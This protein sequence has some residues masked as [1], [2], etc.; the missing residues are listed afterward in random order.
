[1]TIF[2]FT[3]HCVLPENVHTPPMEG[4]WKF[5]GDG[6]LKA[7]LLEELS[8]KLNWNFLDEEGGGGGKTKKFLW[9]GEGGMDIFWYYTFKWLSTSA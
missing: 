6:G 9:G 1:M 7:K 2:S 4:H 5:L 3:A 8:M